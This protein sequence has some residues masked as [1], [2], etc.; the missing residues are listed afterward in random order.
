VIRLP[1]VFPLKRFFRS[2]ASEIALIRRW[3]GKPAELRDGFS[4]SLADAK[5]IWTE[6]GMI[7]C[8]LVHRPCHADVREFHVRMKRTLKAKHDPDAQE[9]ARNDALAAIWSKDIA[10]IGSAMLEGTFAA[11]EMVKL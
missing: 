5:E 11:Q 10:L 1:P 2:G 8:L 3:D 9:T 7:G 6:D 4:T